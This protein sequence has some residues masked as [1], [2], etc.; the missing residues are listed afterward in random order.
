MSKFCEEIKVLLLS[1]KEHVESAVINHGP[2]RLAPNV[3]NLALLPDQ[4]FRK[5][6]QQNE[7]H[8][9]KFHNA[10]ISVLSINSSPTLPFVSPE[11]PQIEIS[12]DLASVGITSASPTILK[13]ISAKAKMFLNK[14][15]MQLS[16]HQPEQE[17]KRTWS[18]AK[19]R[20]DHFTCLL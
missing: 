3:S 19:Q 13:N 6:S 10:K 4:W 5:N 12:V 15:N 18:K 9:K 20:Q 16:K 2:Y 11:M 7:A 1:K 14:V 17:S 8:V